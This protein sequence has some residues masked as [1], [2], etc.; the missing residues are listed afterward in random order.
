MLTSCR[1]SIEESDYVGHYEGTYYDANFL[2]NEGTS[3]VDIVAVNDKKVDAVIN[4]VGVDTIYLYGWNVGIDIYPLGFTYTKI[5]KPGFSSSYT[6]SISINKSTHK[7]D[8]KYDD[9]L[10][11]DLNCYRY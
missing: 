8:L 1:Y 6:N 9:T 7:L 11:F 4:L 2:P 10:M 3:I 5:S